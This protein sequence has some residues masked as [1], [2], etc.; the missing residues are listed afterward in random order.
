MSRFSTAVIGDFRRQYRFGFVMVGVFVTVIAG[1]LLR[2][3]VTAEAAFAIP[4]FVITNLLTTTYFFVAATVLFEKGEGTLEV[5]LVSPLKVSEYLGSKI[6]TLSL[7]A[8]VETLAIIA[9]VFPGELSWL[10]LVLGMLAMSAAYVLCGFALVS[11]FNT[12]TDFLLPSVGYAFLGLVPVLAS[13]GLWENPLLWLHPTRAL[14]VVAE[15]AVRPVSSGELVYGVAYS[16]AT[17]AISYWFA[18]RAFQQL[19]VRTRVVR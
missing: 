1:G 18:R 3:I 13:L 17:L 4:T 14:L 2:L 12:I 15:A 11:R 19:A 9:F 10:P 7:L 16:F 6:F 8:G 5:L